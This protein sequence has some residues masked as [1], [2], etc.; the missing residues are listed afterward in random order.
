MNG[1][2]VEKRAIL[3][4]AFRNYP[5]VVPKPGQE[6]VEY[7]A[8]LVL[9][10]LLALVLS[11]LAALY[12]RYLFGPHLPFARSFF[13]DQ[14]IF[15]LESSWWVFTPVPLALA[16]RRTY[17]RR[18]PFWEE[19]RELTIGVV[20]GFVLVLALVSLGKLTGQ[21]SRLFLCMA[22]LS[23]LFLLPCERYLVKT[24]LF[25]LP[26]FR[27]KAIIL[28][29]G[30]VGEELAQGLERETYLGYEVVGFLDDDLRKRRKKIA[31]KKV[32]GPIENVGK[33]VRFL[34]VESVFIAVPSFSTRRVSEIFAHLQGL[35]R[36]V[37]IVPEFRNIG[38]L[39]AELSC[40]FAQKLLLIRV[41]NNLKSA[42]NQFVKRTFD[43]LVSLAALPLLLPFMLVIACLIRLDSPGAPIFV[44]ERMGYRGRRFRM[45]KFRTMYQN[46]DEILEAYLEKH[47]EARREWYEYKKLRGRDP[48]VTRFGRFLRKASL[49]ELPQ[50]INVLRGDMSLVGPRPYLPRERDDMNGLQGIILLARPG[51]GGLWQVSGRNNLTFQD[52]LRMDVWYVLNWS[53]WLDVT[54]LIRTA[55][56]VFKRDGSC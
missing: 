38:M 18:L 16:Y 56:A 3:H 32:F 43:L 47:P 50:V 13:L 4:E 7:Y 12:L 6:R 19:V 41:Q 51:L 29:A 49:D 44:Q 54:L 31:G 24:L 25:K 5:R 21:F 40:L 2:R 30:A 20:L 53:L 37:S 48:R 23:S 26:M 17:D 46:A 52:R 34:G 9:G 39:N 28:G 14:G 42:S 8:A 10:D 27:R 22:F 33:F 55:R 15:T 36:E 1:H 45:Y 35:V 11:L